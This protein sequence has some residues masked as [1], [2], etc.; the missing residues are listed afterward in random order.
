[1]AGDQKGELSKKEK[2]FLEEFT[3]SM[4]K[5]C[6][7]QLRKFRQDIQQQ[8][9]GRSSRDEY[10][11]KEFD[12]MD[13]NW[14]H[15]GL[16][17]Q[18][19]SFHGKA[20]P[21]AY[22][23]WKK[24]IELI[25]SSQHYAERKKIQMATAEFCGHALRWWNQLIKCRRL[26]GKEPVE[27]WLK[28]R[29]L[30][31]R[32]YVPRQYHKEVIQK[33][34]ETKLCSSLSVQKQQVNKRSS[35]S[36]NLVSSSKT[37]THSFEDSIRKAISQAFRDVEKQFKQ[38]KT[39]SP[40]LEVQNPA[41]SSTVS[42]LKDAEPDSVA[43]SDLAA[44]VQEDQTEIAT[45]TIQKDD[46][47]IKDDLILFKQDVIEE[48]APRESKSD[49]GVEHLFVTD[50]NGFQRTFLGTFLISPFVWNKT[51]AVE[52]SR[53]KLG[54]ENVV[55]EPGGELWNHRN[56]PKIIEKKS[57]ATTI[58]LS[59]L[60]PSEVK[61]LHVSAQQEFHYE[62]NWRML[63]TL[64][65]IQ[66]I[67]QRSKWPLDHEDIVN[68]AKH[69][70][71]SKFC[72]LLISD[73]TGRLQFYL[74]KP[75]AYD[76][77]LIILGKCSARG[78]TSWGNKE[79]EAD[80]NALLLDHVKVWKP[81]DLQ[82]L[83][84][85]FGDCQTKSGDGDFIRV[86][87][88]VITGVGGELMFSFQSKEK[89]PDGLSLHQSPNKPTRVMSAILF[90]RRGYSNNQS[91]K[92]GSLATM[93][94]QQSNLGSCLATSFDIGAVRGSYL[95]NQKELSNKLNCHGNLTHQGL[96]SNWNHV[97]IFSYE[98]V[99]N[100]TSRVILC[101]LC[102]NFSEFRTSQSYLW[103][104]GEHAKVTNHVF[105]SSFIDYTDMMHLF[106]SKE[107]CAD[108]MEALK[109]AKT[110]N[111]REEDKRFKPPNLSQE[112]HQ[113]VT[114][115]I[116]IKEAPPDAA[117]KPK[118]RKYNFGIRLL[119]YDD[120]ACVNLSCFNVSGLSNASR[121]RK[122]KWIS[123]FYLIEPFSDNAY[124]RGLQGKCNLIINSHVTDL[125]PSIAG[126][127]DLRTN[128]FEVGGD[129]VIMESTKEW[130]HEPDHGELVAVEEPTL[131]ECLS[132]NKASI[133]K[134]N[135]IYIQATLH[136]S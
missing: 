38:S 104:P 44:L 75:G 125:V 66:Q 97:Q 105:K 2:L 119:L 80:Q 74:W 36:S 92:N 81:P 93:E 107:T 112:R 7:D 95:S 39:I 89:P 27:T 117:Y 130:N 91:I 51:R 19:P 123:P 52:L 30:M 10:K 132:Q 71:L 59:D 118:P 127:T 135:L 25:F 122:A 134:D 84:Y 63:P 60:L 90:E 136:S 77:I 109:H 86:N 45:I 8:R 65:W 116:L 113:D 83:Q 73:W 61:V 6:K 82:K 31:R 29:A 72:E 67:R 35:P 126:N 37:S 58:V 68:F 48:E 102:L 20:D 53:H 23:K 106:L 79:L 22:V 110:K 18:I 40:S 87:G 69:I 121:V 78:R 42:E 13:R 9:K 64:S 108:Y 94:M 88:E 96:T 11:K 57:A 115:F 111:K 128:L 85:H 33:Q 131:E 15:A 3:A 54:M 103:R 56:N 98:R 46:Q 129:D 101:L 12:Q 4:D 100:F 16:K 24:K 41:P 124:Q 49:S 14:K 34:P 50:S 32:E 55:F 120:L 76:S 62:T 47:P 99:M 43:Q 114:C 5:A 133:I 21:E 1:M 17:Y 28:L 70:G 26:D